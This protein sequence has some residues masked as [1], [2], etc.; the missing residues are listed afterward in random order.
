MLVCRYG[1]GCIT[2][3]SSKN[4]YQN[5]NLSKSTVSERDM[6]PGP[7]FTTKLR[8][9]SKMS[10]VTSPV[11]RA[12]NS[13][14]TEN[15]SLRARNYLSRSATVSPKNKN[16]LKSS[17]YF[18]YQKILAKRYFRIKVEPIF[19]LL[20]PTGPSEQLGYRAVSSFFFSK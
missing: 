17:W 5:R 12:T 1:C 4:S 13:R 15:Q 14:L 10:R 9:W 6:F 7:G 3:K 11:L 18:W 2:N 16:K 8:I 20:L 19:C